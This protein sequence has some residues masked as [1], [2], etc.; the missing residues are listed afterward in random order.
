MA[1]ERP[2]GVTI[3]AIL[4]FIGGALGILGGIILTF[5]LPSLY[6]FTGDEILGAVV[7]GTAIGLVIY[8]IISIVYSWGLWTGKSWAWLL[9]MFFS[10]LSVLSILLLNIV[11]AVIGAIV[12]WYFLKPHVKEYFGVKVEYST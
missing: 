9:G 12:I 3:L 8:G 7:V 2:L 5:V 6:G 11:G 4:G 10:G 1:D